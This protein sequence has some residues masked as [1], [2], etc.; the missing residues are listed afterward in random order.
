[1]HNVPR[2]AYIKKLDRMGADFFGCVDQMKDKLQ[3]TPAICALPVGQA[4]EFKGVI[5]LV[6]M[7]YIERDLS[8]PRNVNYQLVDIP[9]SH[10][11]LAEEWHH[12]LLEAASH[13]D[14]HLVELIIE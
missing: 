2:L 9:A 8:D 1:M 5:D 3:V 14:D 11:A 6:E 4:G 13:V 12:H 7:K 10:R